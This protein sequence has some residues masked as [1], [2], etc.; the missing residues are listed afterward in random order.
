MGLSHL[1]AFILVAS[2]LVVIVLFGV[3]VA[4]SEGSSS[5]EFS[6]DRTARKMAGVQRSRHMEEKEVGKS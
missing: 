5:L 6:K 1:L 4:Y 2:F 3:S